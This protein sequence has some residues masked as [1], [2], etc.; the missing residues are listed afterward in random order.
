[1][2]IK[3]IVRVLISNIEKNRSYETSLLSKVQA[4]VRSN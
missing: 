2:S 3:G 1:M 4:L